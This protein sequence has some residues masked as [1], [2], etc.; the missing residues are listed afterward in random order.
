[1]DAI[2]PNDEPTDE[3][4]ASSE[5]DGPASEAPVVDENETGVT[6]EE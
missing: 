5:A 3:L 2:E 4:T 1:V 6:G